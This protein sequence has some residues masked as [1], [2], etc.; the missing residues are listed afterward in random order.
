MGHLHKGSSQA[1][2]I[3]RQHCFLIKVCY[4]ESE[5]ACDLEQFHASHCHLS[6]MVRNMDMCCFG[7]VLFYENSTY[8]QLCLSLDSTNLSGHFGL[9]KC[10]SKSGR[11]WHK[12]LLEEGL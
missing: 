12:L 1:S 8:A 10:E 11:G 4:Q 9:L 7:F 6:S 3:L 5:V 2:T